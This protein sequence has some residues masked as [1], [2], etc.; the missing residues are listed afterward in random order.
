[1]NK[2]SWWY[3]FR[4][5]WRYDISWP[6]GCWIRTPLFALGYL[7]SGMRQATDGRWTGWAIDWMPLDWRLRI[8]KGSTLD[9]HHWDNWRRAS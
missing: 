1:M 9:R 7:R 2:P 4:T 5:Y 8:A 3:C 6:H